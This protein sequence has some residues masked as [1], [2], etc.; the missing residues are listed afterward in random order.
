MRISSKNLQCVH[1]QVKE[2]VLETLDFDHFT[3]KQLASEVRKS[4]LYPSD[5]IIER[6]A[7]LYENKN[8]HLRPEDKRQYDFWF[9]ELGPQAGRLS[10]EKVRN[11]LMEWSELPDSTLDKIL[12]LPDQDKDGFLDRYEFRVAYHLHVRADNGDEIPDQVVISPLSPYSIIILYI[13]AS[14]WTV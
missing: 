4:G 6:M 3:A 9:D 5:K 10:E 1:V 13:T 14:R 11:F 12:E 8:Y 7:Q 2:E